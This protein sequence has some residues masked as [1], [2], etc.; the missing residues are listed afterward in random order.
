MGKEPDWTVAIPVYNPNPEYLQQAL[1][2]VVKQ[3]RETK[4]AQI[5]VFDDASTQDYVLPDLYYPIHVIQHEENQGLA[6]T[7]N[8]AIRYAEGTYLHI[9]H[10]DDYVLD[11][12][13]QEMEKLLNWHSEIGAAFCR[14]IYMDEEGYWK[15]FS[16]LYPKRPGLFT[17]FPETISTRQI[18]ECPTI[19]VKTEVY[20]NLGG[21]RE[22]LSYALD[23]EMW[24]RIGWNY[25]V[26]YH[27]Q[28]MAC[29][30]VH[31]NSQT[32]RLRKHASS[33]YD[34]LKAI[35]IIA[36]LFPKDQKTQLYRQVLEEKRKKG[37][38]LLKEES[39]PECR[40]KLK[41]QLRK[42]SPGFKE[43]LQIWLS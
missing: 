32:A 10:Q 22:D 9:L 24:A 31:K 20:E 2:S 19:A 14:T 43:R 34:E 28:P 5:L 17:N 8:D 26:A 35:P 21:F 1:E 3:F 30:R 12:Y 38:K 13:Y 40:K 6:N 39:D 16:K 11:G 27:P 41:A 33:F 4:R 7:W 18:L 37:A 15:G 29:F 42:I 36:A 23:W 25:K